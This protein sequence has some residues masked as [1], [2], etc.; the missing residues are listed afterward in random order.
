M[1]INVRKDTGSSR[2]RNCVQERGSQGTTLNSDEDIIDG[3]RGHTRATPSDERLHSRL[4]VRR[5]FRVKG[6]AQSNI[7]QVAASYFCV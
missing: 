3:Q 4:H 7:K 1:L 6:R 5:G 2:E